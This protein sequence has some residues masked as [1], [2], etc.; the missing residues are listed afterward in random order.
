MIFFNSAI[1]LDYLKK[2]EENALCEK[3]WR[4]LQ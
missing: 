1:V 2:N 3:Q 4:E